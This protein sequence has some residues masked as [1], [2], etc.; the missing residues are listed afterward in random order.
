MGQ[1]SVSE[2]K[3]RASNM[4][5][6]ELKKRDVSYANLCCRLQEI[7]LRETV[8]SVTTKINRG[9]FSFTFFLQCANVIGSTTI[10]LVD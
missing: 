9:T 7:G 4:L 3:K 6:A 10:H 2:W 5:K 8:A 1:L